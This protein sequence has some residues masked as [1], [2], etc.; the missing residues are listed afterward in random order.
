VVKRS[1]AVTGGLRVWS[2][3]LAVLAVTVALVIA[4]ITVASVHRYWSTHSFAASVLSGVLVLLLTVLIVDRVTR[5]RQLRNQSQA[6]AA[7][8]V[9]IVGQA[10]RAAD[11]IS[12]SSRP[13]ENLDAISDE[14]R[15]YTQMLLMSAPVLIDTK[16]SRTFLEMAQR[17]AGQLSRTLRASGD[18]QLQQEKAQL[19]ARVEQ[20]REAARPL[21]EALSRDQ[22]V[23]VASDGT[24][25]GETGS[26]MPNPV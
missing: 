13:A 7:E 14:A 9:I 12:T 1:L 23:A 3:A 17:V 21:L 20:L 16:V 18:E 26:G 4:D 10:K 11:A 15:T 2:G 5:I 8:A 6:I 22:R 25:S 24:D 19:D